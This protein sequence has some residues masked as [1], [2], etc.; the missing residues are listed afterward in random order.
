MQSVHTITTD[1]LTPLTLASRRGHRD[2]AELLLRH[3]A[4]VNH[5]AKVTRGE[6]WEVATMVVGAFYCYGFGVAV[7][8]SEFG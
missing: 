8:I 4:D 3:K 2:I 5:R 6:G 1:T 7:W